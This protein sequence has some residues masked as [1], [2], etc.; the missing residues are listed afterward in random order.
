M[1]V[2]FWVD[3]ACPWCWM[4]ARWAVD[5]VTPVR[6]LAI[7]WEPISLLFKNNPSE[8]D[9]FHEPN[10]FTHRLL[11]VMQAVKRAEG[12]EAARRLYWQYG[13][14][15]HHDRAAGTVDVAAVLGG[16]AGPFLQ[17][18]G[19]PTTYASAYD[20]D[21][22]DDV[23]RTRMQVGLDLV[24][25]DV[26]TP[27]IG[28]DTPAGQ[29]GVFGPILSRLPEGDHGIELWDAMTTFATF[30]GFWE[31]KRTRTEDPIFPGR[32]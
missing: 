28:F 5:V 31:L 24:G 18:A 7:S 25:N 9:P 17:A 26:G 11:R 21:S 8:D 29:R 13:A 19:L 16:G 14:V 23:I 3:P 32:P 2:S 1:N 22:W 10:Q 15:L 27:I 4:T 20:D 12:D 6:N 30:D